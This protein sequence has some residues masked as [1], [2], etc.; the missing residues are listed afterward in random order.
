MIQ[1]DWREV[2]LTFPLSPLRLYDNTTNSM[3]WWRRWF[4]FRRVF[5]FLDFRPVAA[6][7]RGGESPEIGDHYDISCFERLIDVVPHWLTFPPIFDVDNL[8]TWRLA[9]ACDSWL[10]WYG[11][12][13]HDGPWALSCGAFLG[14]AQLHS[15]KWRDILHKTAWLL[16]VGWGLYLILIVLGHLNLD[17]RRV[18]L[19]RNRL[20]VWRLRLDPIGESVNHMA[21]LLTALP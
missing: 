17:L 6:E 19:H 14:M 13:T 4:G 18:D 5:N 3:S 20:R 11:A 2:W 9:L 8:E 16:C 10:I 1:G 7:K 15:T 12:A 21:V